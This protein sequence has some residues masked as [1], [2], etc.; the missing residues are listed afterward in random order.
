MRVILVATSNSKL[1]RDKARVALL[2]Q[3]LQRF[4]WIETVDLAETLFCADEEALT[5]PAELRAAELMRIFLEQDYQIILDISGGDACNEILSY[6]DWTQLQ[7]CQQFFL[8]Y[9]DVSV[10]LNVLAERTQMK[11]F[12]FNSL[13][14][15]GTAGE[16]Q[17]ADF[18]QIILQPS[19]I[20]ESLQEVVTQQEVVRGGNLRCSLKLA[21]TPWWPD[22]KHKT[23]LIESLSGQWNRIRSLL[24]QYEQM[25]TFEQIDKI[26]VG[27]FQELQECQQYG[28]LQQYLL[29]KAAEYQF[30]IKETN[31]IGHHERSKPLRYYIG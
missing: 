17:L 31:A 14:L 7:A 6:L 26:I 12:N 25:G 10:L 4:E 9:S 23:L 24:T 21:G 29:E 20:V 13:T 11:V 30:V 5:V 22:F 8:G 18:E 27:Q 28:Y 19:H 15:I 1:Q 16:E 3:A 2:Q